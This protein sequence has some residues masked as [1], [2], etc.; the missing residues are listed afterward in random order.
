M[1][2]VEEALK[3]VQANPHSTAVVELPL[4]ASV[5]KILAENIL[6]DRDFPPFNRVAMDGLAFCFEK[7]DFQKITIENIQFAGEAQK[8]L[9]DASKGIE[10]MTGAILPLGCDTV[11]RYEDINIQQ[12]GEV[13]FA[14]ISI[15]KEEIVKGQNVHVQGSDRHAGEVL[16]QKGI[17]ISPAEIAVMASVGKSKVQVQ[18]TPKIAIISTGD[19]L[20]E[21]D[22]TPLA[23]QI[24]T[25]NAYMLSA[26]LQQIGV[27]ASTFHLIDEEKVLYQK[28]KEIIA[29]YDILLL[30]GGVSAGKKDFV[31][32]I[33]ADL[34]LE[35]LFHKVA[36][37]PGKPMWFGKTPTGKI[38]FALP[39][40]PVSTF[41]CFCKYVL[42][43]LKS[44]SKHEEVILDKDI[45][46]KPDLT[47]FVPVKTYFE[48]G[49]M[50]AKPFLGSGSADFANLTDC[51]GFVELPAQKQIFKAGEVFSFVRFR[52]L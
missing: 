16:L 34:G 13:K 3:I 21:I 11:V 20:V 19:E 10:V 27:E 30:S 47:Y 50:M 39:G 14:S 48:A 36:Q 37:K 29:T 4:M 42:P 51:D 38:I 9:Q 7:I 40:N 22:K 15:A 46:F 25:S 2:S 23:Y 8:T 32:A 28:L 1:I 35:K 52:G 5:G 24:R 43:T 17:K 31:P 6:A 49:K 18:S 26:A 41:L 33:L 12:D 44:E 45:I